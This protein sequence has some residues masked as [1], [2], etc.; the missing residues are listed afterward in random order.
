M[1]ISKTRATTVMA[2]AVIAY[3]SAA[4]A[5]PANPEGRAPPSKADRYALGYF[6]PKTKAAASFSQRLVRCPTTDDTRILVETHAQIL[7]KTVPDFA[8]LYRIDASAGFLA[9]RSTELLL[10][11]D[12][13]MKSVNATVEGQGTAV[14]V[15]TVK[16][17]AFAA[18]LAIGGPKGPGFRGEPPKELATRCRPQIAALLTEIDGLAENMSKLE[19]RLAASGLTASE[20]AELASARDR[21]SAIH[22]AVTLSSQPVAI[23]PTADG[24]ISADA[25][26]YG[27]WFDR[28]NPLD[29][30][31]LPG[32]DGVL[33]S[34]K[35][36][37]S[38]QTALTSA[39][40]VPPGD[41]SKLSA[42]PE[43]VIYYRRPVPVAMSMVPCTLNGNKRH[44]KTPL[45]RE[46]GRAA[47]K[48]QTCVVDQTPEAGPL[49]TDST[50]G[51]LQLSGLFRLPIGRGG[52][53]GSRTVATEF[54]ASGA[55]TSL[56]Y[57]SSPGAAD[58]ASAIDAAREGGTTIRDARADALARK[59][60]ILKSRK[61]IQDLEAELDKQQ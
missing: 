35:I 5:A 8:R 31:K 34:W 29:L 11:S 52:L 50:A 21:L 38:A 9:K 36:N 56:K 7:A 54:D 4:V 59:A 41:V 30:S 22:D 61:D 15:S 2:I 51:F 23:D 37:A 39:A 25:L 47:D 57:G 14:I 45:K 24:S 6:L 1:S 16:L 44:D 3:S 13:T 10:N 40:Y 49:T 55:P 26:D 48:S 19:A 60:A 32:D 27:E 18:S 43:A 17:A 33:V 28:V 58:L 53:F 12:G 42:L 46:A 20:T